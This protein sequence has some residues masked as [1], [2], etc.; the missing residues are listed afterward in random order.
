MER[1]RRFFAEDFG[2]RIAG[3]DKRRAR[4]A[5]ADGELQGSYTP[6]PTPWPTHHYTNKKVF[7][8]I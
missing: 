3:A 2:S 4:D 7:L 8:A 1:T 6:M 5:D